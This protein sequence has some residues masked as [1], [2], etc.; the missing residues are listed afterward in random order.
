MWERDLYGG[1]TRWWRKEIK[2]MGIIAWRM[3]F[4]HVYNSKDK[5]N[6]NAAKE[7]L[8]HN[9]MKV[10]Q[11]NTGHRLRAPLRIGEFFSMCEICILKQVL[12][13]YGF[14]FPAR[15]TF[16]FHPCLYLPKLKVSLSWLLTHPPG[17]LFLHPTPFLPSICACFLLGVCDFWQSP[18]MPRTLDH[19]TL[20]HSKASCSISSINILYPKSLAFIG[21]SW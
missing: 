11:V 4:M 7:K 10:I 1:E 14:S 8:N 15:Q 12:V 16:H 20:G 13:S 5:P 19:F 17:S 2:G 21:F 3:H 9:K 6:K 18:R